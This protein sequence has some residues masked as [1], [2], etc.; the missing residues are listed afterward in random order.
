MKSGSIRKASPGTIQEEKLG[1][2]VSKRT[3]T[4]RQVVI[5]FCSFYSTARLPADATHAEV[6][7]LE[8]FLDAVL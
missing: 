4:V 7:D 8:E 6:F 5:P 2:T 1:Q 3:S